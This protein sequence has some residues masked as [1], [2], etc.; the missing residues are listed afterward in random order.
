M[1][2]SLIVLIGF[3]TFTWNQQAGNNLARRLFASVL[4]TAIYAISILVLIFTFG[5]QIHLIMGGNL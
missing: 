1:L 4:C 2:V 5:I 3:F